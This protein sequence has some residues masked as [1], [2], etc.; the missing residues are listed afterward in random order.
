MSG[1]LVQ[2]TIPVVLS[3]ALAGAPLKYTH[4]TA[5]RA[6]KATPFITIAI[7]KVLSECINRGAFRVCVHVG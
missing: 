7:W 3:F 2:L 6:H 5:I 4:T 1:M